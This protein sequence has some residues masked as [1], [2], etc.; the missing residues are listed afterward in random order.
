MKMKQSFLAIAI[1]WLLILTSC[2][3]PAPAAPQE[4]PTAAASATEE[5]APPQVGN[6][7]LFATISELTGSVQMKPAG[8][9]SFIPATTDTKITVSSQ[10]QTGADGKARLDLSSGTIIRVAPSSLFTLV[11]NE[12]TKAGLWTK[13][14]MELGKVFIILNGGSTE[15]QTPAGVAAVQGSYLKVEFDPQ[16][17][18]L[19]LTCLEGNCSVVAPNGEIRKFTNGQKIIIRKDPQT[20]GWIIDEQ[21]MTPED[22]AEWLENNP[23]AKELVESALEGGAN[24]GT[25]NDSCFT[26]LQPPSGAKLPPQGVVK[27][28]WSE[29]PGAA[30]YLVKFINASGKTIMFETSGTKLEQYIEGFVPQEGQVSWSVTALDENGNEICTTD[31]V[32]FSKPDSKWE[33]PKKEKEEEPNYYNPYGYG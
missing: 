26:I 15:V 8:Q 7:A 14:T 10:I 31:P 20:G 19:I 17:G 2:Q 6:S 5:A 18:E 3:Q 29:Q 32:T 27:F 9:N 13:I 23:E 28:E 21:L 24:N 33:K 11:S 1:A 25:G 16:V 12:E 4:K 30:K 22:F